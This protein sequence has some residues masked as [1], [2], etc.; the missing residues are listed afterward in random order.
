MGKSTISMVIFNGY[1]KL[2]EGS[3]EKNKST[4]IPDGAPYLAQ[5]VVK[6]SNT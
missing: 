2:P 4:Q 5:P 6:N 1:V 3:I